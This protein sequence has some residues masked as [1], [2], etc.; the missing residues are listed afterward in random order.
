MRLLFVSVCGAVLAASG[1]V[2]VH[3]LV[4]MNHDGSGTLTETITI[5]PR[6]VRM[7]EGHAKR[8]G[9]A[10]DGFALLTEEALKQRTASFGEVTLKSKETKVLPD[11]SRMIKAVFEFKDVNKIN[12]Y[13]VP[14]FQTSSK[15]R[16]GL[17][18]FRY[19]RIVR[20][21][22]TPPNYYKKDQL[23]VVCQRHPTQ[24]K[25]SSP[26]IQ[27]QFRDVT[28]I[29]QDMLKDFYF[30]IQIQAP[31]DIETFDDKRDMVGGMPFDRDIVI[32]YRVTGADVAATP[33]LI[34][35]M[36]MGEFGGMSNA[37]GGDWRR[38]ELGMP[39]THTP[40]GS[41]YGGMG[42]HFFKTVRVSGPDAQP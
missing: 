42:V 4:K 40:Y 6:A 29:F 23:N 26:E 35:G 39:N 21:W 24:Q 10:E 30:E 37:W 16:T 41:D 31:D 9:Q 8:T 7:L 25:F 38:M 17:L 19:Q 34:R 11:G 28:P 15:D 22:E 27:Q 33:E 36:L 18:K 20:G 12:L 32:P 3:Q 2:R 1:C 14:T 5:L 13:I